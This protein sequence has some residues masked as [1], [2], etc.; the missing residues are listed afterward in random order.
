MR[1]AGL[2]HWPEVPRL[3]RVVGALPT[4][5]IAGSADP[6]AATSEENPA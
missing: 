6:T 5:A 3:V 4:T 2:H 1:A